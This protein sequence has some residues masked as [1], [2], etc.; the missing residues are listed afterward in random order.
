MRQFYIIRDTIENPKLSSIL[1]E[2]IKVQLPNVEV[3][4]ITTKEQRKFASTIKNAINLDPFTR[5]SFHQTLD[6]ARVFQVDEQSKPSGYINRANTKP[7]K[8]QILDIPKGEYYIIDDDICSG[9]TI[10]YIKNLIN[11]T[12]PNI[13][14]IKEYSLIHET[15]PEL[16]NGEAILYDTIDTHD[17]MSG[18]INSGLLI[19][20][21][22]ENNRFLYIHK[23]VNLKNRAKLP[24]PELF[25]SMFNELIK[26]I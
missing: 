14:I 21:N 26:K 3:F 24:N 8:E 23:N 20:E 25:R 9:G 18:Q 22:G 12:N 10:S 4:S 15:I 6:I 1:L 11:E 17:F 16:K 7:L 13:K 2:L 5:T 19:N